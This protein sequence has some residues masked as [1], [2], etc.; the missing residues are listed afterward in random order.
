MGKLYDRLDDRLRAFIAA[1]PLFFVA[2]APSEGGHVNVSPKGYRDTFAV[3]DDRTVAYLDMHGSGAETIAHLRENGRITVMFCSF[4]RTPKI[5]RL[6]GTGRIV[7]PGA[8]D[9]PELSAL[10]PSDIPG[11]RSVIVIALDRIADSCGYG[12]PYMEFTGDRDHLRDWALRK[13]P[14]DFADYRREKNT[15]SID[16]L[17]AL[18]LPTTEAS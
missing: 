4:E 16:G 2:T 13:T 18:P 14:A 3:V 7:T 15:T 12:V 9:W 11:P 1:Q 10:F 17:P 8:P 5:L 6:Y